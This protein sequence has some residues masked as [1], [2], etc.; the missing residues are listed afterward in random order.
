VLDLPIWVEE[1]NQLAV[2]RPVAPVWVMEGETLHLE[3]VADDLDRPAQQLRFH[4]VEGP[5][6]MVVGETGN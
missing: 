2:I 3:L 4:L 6:G 5:E 1:A